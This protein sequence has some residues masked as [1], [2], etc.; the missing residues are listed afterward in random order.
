MLHSWRAVV[1]EAE[2]RGARACAGCD[3]SVRSARPVETAD[4]SAARV[5]SSSACNQGGLGEGEDGGGRGDEEGADTARWQCALV[6]QP[7]PFSEG[8]MDEPVPLQANSQQPAA[9]RPAGRGGSGSLAPR[10]H[11]PAP[12][13]STAPS[14]LRNSRSLAG[15]PSAVRR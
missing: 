2:G 4:G 1:P 14:R 9:S 8:A 15:H 5:A 11:P 7:W 13:R 6:A 12:A 3:G 10:Q